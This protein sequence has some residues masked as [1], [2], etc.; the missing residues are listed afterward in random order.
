MNK[1]IITLA[2]GA[3][4]DGRKVEADI[5]GQLAL[6]DDND[7]VT[8]VNVSHVKSGCLVAVFYLY[9]DA[10]EFAEKASTLLDYD[11]YAQSIVDIGVKRTHAKFKNELEAFKQ[12]RAGYSSYRPQSMNAVGDATRKLLKARLQS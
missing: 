2:M 12:L 4:P 7:D 11:A 5:I 10:L 1:Q 8:V 6:H 9:E 3:Y